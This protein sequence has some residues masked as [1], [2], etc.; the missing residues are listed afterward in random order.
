MHF[1]GFL[2]PLFFKMEMQNSDH[3]DDYDLMF[4]TNYFF[5]DA[6]HSDHANS[7]FNIYPSDQYN[8]TWNYTLLTCFL[9]QLPNFIKRPIKPFKTKIK[10]PEYHTK[11]TFVDINDPQVLIKVYI[12]QIISVVD[13]IKFIKLMFSQ[14]RYVGYSFF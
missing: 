10:K 12:G 5:D 9:N 6:F 13:S 14:K 8:K 3:N 4:V 1:D 2:R 7:Y 11:F